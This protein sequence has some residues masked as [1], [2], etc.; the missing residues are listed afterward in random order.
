MAF[1]FRKKRFFKT[2]LDEF[3]QKL[4]SK[5]QDTTSQSIEKIKAKK[6]TIQ[7]DNEK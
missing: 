5:N 4:F 3:M 6:I 2:E 7:R 1:F